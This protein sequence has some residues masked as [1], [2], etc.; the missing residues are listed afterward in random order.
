V[1]HYYEVDVVQ[2]WVLQLKSDLISLPLKAYLG[3]WKTTKCEL[4]KLP[5]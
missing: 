3:P 1:A 2:P 4:N 5:F